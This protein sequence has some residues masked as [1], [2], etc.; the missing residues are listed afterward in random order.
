MQPMK[1]RAALCNTAK[2]FRLR[3]LRGQSRRRRVEQGKSGE[4]ARRLEEQQRAE[5][6]VRTEELR[7]AL[8]EVR[9]AREAAK[10]AEDGCVKLM[11]PSLETFAGDA[12]ILVTTGNH[13]LN[14][15]LQGRGVAPAVLRTRRPADDGPSTIA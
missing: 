3:R 13:F 14:C 5:L 15:D 9:L 12:A 8:E 4:D 1:T 6:V 7:K 11:I 2:I 10:A